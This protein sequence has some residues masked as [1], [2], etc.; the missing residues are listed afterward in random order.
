[1]AL[2]MP[3]N[4]ILSYRKVARSYFGLLDV[5]AH[6]HTSVLAQTDIHTFSS[7]LISLDSGLRNLEPSISSQC[8][9]AV[10]N[11]AASYLKNSQAFGAEVTSPAAQAIGQHLQQRPELLPQ[12]MTTLFEIVLFDDCS[13]QWSLSRPMLA[14]ILINEPIFNNL[15]R[16]LIS[17]QPKDR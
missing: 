15:K 5:L 9:T 1:M 10:E 16:Q 6:N 2:C 7:I 12:L 8:A 3:L 4:D 11:L 14:L 13:N 17:T